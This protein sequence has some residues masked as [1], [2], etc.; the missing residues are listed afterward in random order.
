MNKLTLL[1]FTLLF[2]LSCESKVKDKKQD[3]GNID[4]ETAIKLSPSELKK[5]KVAYFASGCFWCVE[6]IYED[7]I[8]VKEVVSGYS[9]GTE[10]NPTYEQVGR[11]L[12]SHAEAVKVYYDPKVVD[13]KTLVKVFFGSHD[14]TT[15][16]RQGPDHGAQYRSIAFYSNDEEKK[17]IEDYISQLTKDKVYSAPIVTQVKPFDKFYDAEEY[18][19]DYE[20]LN[21]NNPYIINISIPR[22]NRFKAKYPELLKKGAH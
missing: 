2:S 19:Q 17:I 21:P 18:H 22:Y 15:L 8:G 5:Y 7:V 1:A 11:G 6:A 3:S 14:P 16:N 9:G 4:T 13:F 20:K 10:K 12:T